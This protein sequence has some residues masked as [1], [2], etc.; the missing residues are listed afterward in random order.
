ME[1]PA[2][3]SEERG[4]SPKRS[5]LSLA[6]IPKATIATWMIL[7]ETKAMQ[8]SAKMMYC[9][10]MLAIG[11]IVCILQNNYCILEIVTSNM[12]VCK[13]NIIQM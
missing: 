12:V 1:Q 3:R 13:E 10:D 7:A 8:R 2:L 6:F 9:R 5:R 11:T 4:R